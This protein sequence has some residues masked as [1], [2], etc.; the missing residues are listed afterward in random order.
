MDPNDLEEGAQGLIAGVTQMFFPEEDDPEADRTTI[1][2]R[3]PEKKP[4]PAITLRRMASIKDVPGT[5]TAYCEDCGDPTDECSCHVDSEDEEHE[6][7]LYCAGC[8]SCMN[9]TCD[10]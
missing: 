1:W 5:V 8:I 4:E 6:E 3:F 7:C 10:D 9:C 2:G